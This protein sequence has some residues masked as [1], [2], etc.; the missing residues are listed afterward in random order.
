MNVEETMESLRLGNLVRARD[1]EIR[2]LRTI[3][4][5]LLKALIDTTDAFA[6]LCRCAECTMDVDWEALKE[7]RA[8][9][10]KA[11]GERESRTVK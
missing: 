9:I 6:S 2:Y 1:G 7:A 5:D 10:A 4:V 11:M 3:N 8:A